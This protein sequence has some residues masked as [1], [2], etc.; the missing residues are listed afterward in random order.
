MHTYFLQKTIRALKTIKSDKVVSKP[1]PLDMILDMI[2]QSTPGF[3]MTLEHV[4]YAHLHPR[5]IS[6]EHLKVLDPPFNDPQH[7][8]EG[9][10]IAGAN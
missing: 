7:A 8:V 4:K 3:S 10:S 2:D 1:P 6:T 9:F 5:S